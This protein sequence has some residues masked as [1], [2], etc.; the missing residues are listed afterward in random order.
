MLQAFIAGSY[1]VM[2]CS[3]IYSNVTLFIESWFFIML[4]DLL[5]YTVM[6]GTD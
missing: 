4:Y 2:F 5:E 3:A 6:I 1:I